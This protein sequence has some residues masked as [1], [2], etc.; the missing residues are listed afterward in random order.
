MCVKSKQGQEDFCEQDVHH[1]NATTKLSQNVGATKH[2]VPR[3]SDGESD[4]KSYTDGQSEYVVNLTKMKLLEARVLDYD[5]MSPFIVTYLIDEYAL[6]VEYL[7][8]DRSDTGVNL[9]KQSSKISL[10][11]KILFQRDLYNNCVDDY[12]IVS[13]EW[14]L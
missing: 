5:I 14:T 10:Q 13:Y 8:G 6:E 12:D 7:W 9:F 2:Y 11:Q 4:L 1:K 3:N